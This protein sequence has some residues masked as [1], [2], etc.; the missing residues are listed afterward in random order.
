MVHLSRWSSVA[1][2]VIASTPSGNCHPVL[3][4]RLGIA[5][6]LFSVLFAKRSA[7]TLIMTFPRATSL[8]LAPRAERFAIV[9]S[10]HKVSGR[11]LLCVFR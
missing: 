11:S 10:A 7:I 8:A 2:G 1:R 3:V 6:E 5:R 4:T 9:G